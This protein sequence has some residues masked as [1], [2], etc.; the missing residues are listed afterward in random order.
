MCVLRIRSAQALEAYWLRLSLSD[1]SERVVDVSPY[2]YGPIF[3]PVR[4]D[5]AVFG[6]VEVDPVLGS[7]VWPN[8]ADI[9]P[10]VLLLGR[11]PARPRS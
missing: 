9:D 6:S 8:G 10:D 5:P 3:E 2:L 1:G 11:P 4:R 7:V